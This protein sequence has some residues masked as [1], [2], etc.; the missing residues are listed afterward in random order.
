MLPGYFQGIIICQASQNCQR[1]AVRDHQ[2]RA[3]RMSLHDLIRSRGYALRHF[4]VRFSAWGARIQ[5][6]KLIFSDD[7]RIALANICRGLTFPIA[8]TNLTQPTVLPYFQVQGF[9]NHLRGLRCPL[10]IT[11]IKRAKILLSQLGRQ[12]VRLGQAGGVQR[13]IRLTLQAATDVPI[14]LPMTDE[15]EF[16]HYQNYMSDDSFHL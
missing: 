10:Q 3:G 15:P 9:T 5:R 4:T 16:S 7:L 12:A 13:D 2:N 6:M 11:R 14:G 8:K 1:P